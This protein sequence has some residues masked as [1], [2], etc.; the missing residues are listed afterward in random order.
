MGDAVAESKDG[1]AMKYTGQLIEARFK[2][3]P[4]DHQFMEFESFVEEHARAKAWTM[5]TGKTKAAIDKACHLYKIGEIDGV[6][7]F[8]PNGVHANWVEREV[9]VH[10]WPGVEYKCL[11][12]RS[13][14]AGSKGGN[15]LS[16]ADRVEWAAQQAEWWSTLKTVRRDRRLMYLAINTESMT[17]KDVRKAAANFI[18]YRRV[19]VIFDE[20]DDFGTPGSKRTKMARAL[21]RRCPYRE[22]DSGTMLTGS[23]LAAFSQFEL[24]EK[25]ALGFSTY[26]EFKARYAI[27]EQQNFGLRKFNKVVGYKNEDELRERIARFTSVVL[28]EDTD[29]PDLVFDTA[30]IIP[31]EEQLRIY[32]DLYEDFRIAIENNEVSVGSRAPRFQKMQ[33]VFSGFV[34]DE[35]GKTVMIP[36][37]NPRLEALVRE[38]YLAPGKVVIW[39]A[40]QTDMDLVKAH[41]LAEGHKVVEYHGRVSDKVK[42]ESLHSFRENRDIKALIGH[43]QSGGRG[44]D[45]SVASS[46]FNYSHTFKARLRVQALERA[47]K[48]GGKNIRVLDF[49]AP[50]PDQRILKVTRERIDIADYIAGT[51]MKRFLEGL[52]L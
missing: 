5:R 23:P 38:V 16:K 20:S 42:S 47:T 2:T 40:Y 19:F 24:L 25:G 21:A 39:C 29:M 31:T 15:R 26:N 27:E 13:S 28:R 52:K 36:G 33:Q 4:Y 22:I 41:L 3:A 49:V 6:L 35:S 50:G 30:P 34:K 46:I 51:G 14:V 43:T 45:M 48:I 8:A 7:I 44:V 11:T 32:R 37:P 17:R 18:K 1:T 12:W 10:S 9:P